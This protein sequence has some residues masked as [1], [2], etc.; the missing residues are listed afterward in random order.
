MKAYCVVLMCL[1]VCICADFQSIGSGNVHSAESEEKKGDCQLIA[2]PN[3]ISCLTMN[4]LYSEQTHVFE[5]NLNFDQFNG[6]YV[7]CH[8][9]FRVKASPSQMCSYI[10]RN[11][12]GWN[13]LHDM[14]DDNG[15]DDIKIWCDA[16]R[17]AF[18]YMLV[19]LVL[20]FL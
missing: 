16:K 12:D 17:V 8:V 6:K 11:E 20:M 4:E 10:K 1:I 14:I 2:N 15:G 19:A 9:T 5:D 7:C 18:S 13:D 3:R